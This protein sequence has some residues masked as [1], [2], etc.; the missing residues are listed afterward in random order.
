[1]NDEGRDRVVKG[2]RL[3]AE[4][5]R[6]VQFGNYTGWIDLGGQRLEFDSREPLWGSRDRSWG[7]RL[8]SRTDAS[9]PPVTQFRAMMFMWVC[10][11]FADS[12]LHFFLKENSPTD[13]RSL[14]GDETFAL[15]SNLPTRQIV[16]VEHD[17]EWF[18][19]AY[20]QHLKGGSY[21]VHF[22]D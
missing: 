15:K 20:A 1:P 2:D 8:E 7:L 17:L 18:D 6:Y 19:D 12:G 11:Q 4:V 14:V 10:G 9:H 22:E 3:I 5:S 16:R 21:V 13:V